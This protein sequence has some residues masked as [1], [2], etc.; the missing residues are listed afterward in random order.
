MSLKQQFSKIIHRKWLFKYRVVIMN[1]STLEEVNTFRLNRL[2]VFVY[3]GLFA[4]LMITLT[5]LVIIYSPLKQY[6]LGFSE[7]DLRKQIVDLTFQT[8]SL[9]QRIVS[10]DA[11]FGSLQKVL[12]GDIEPD[13]INKDSVL[14]AVQQIPVEVDIQAS[15]EEMKLRGEVAEEERYNVFDV[16]TANTRKAFFPPIQ[17]MLSSEFKADKRHYGIDLTAAEGTPVKAIGE[18]TVIFAEWSAQTGFVLI[19][20][21]PHNFVSVYKHNASITKRQGDKV[22][23]GEVIAQVGNTGELSTGVHLHFEL[24]HEGYPVDPLNY[25]NIK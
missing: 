1:E 12:T 7:A 3:S 13:K 5:T 11:Y 2:N 21:H 19:I 10:N 20:E 9:Q 17:G 23:A 22:R 6:I 25:M 14:N 8:D 4:I 24:W 15:E 16:A 18:G